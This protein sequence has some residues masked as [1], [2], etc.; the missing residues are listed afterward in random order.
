MNKEDVMLV[1]QLLHTMQDVLS[2][3]EIYYKKK[4]IPK[5]NSAK[6]ELLILQKRI[7]ER[8]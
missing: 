8:I 7:N 2:K 5:F 6:E 1:A 3:L 4:D